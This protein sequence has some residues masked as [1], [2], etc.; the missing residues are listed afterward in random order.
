M[1]TTAIYPSVDQPWLKY[2]D[3]TK[4][5]LPLPD[6]TL[7]EYT[8]Q[9]NQGNL[10]S[11]AL[12]YFGTKVSYGQFFDRIRET[13]KAFAA[14]GIQKGDIVTIMSIST[15][16]T[17][18][19]IFALNYMG[20]VGNMVYM[21][22]SEHE[23]LQNLEFTESKLFMVLDPALDRVNKIKD[24]LTVPTVVL[25]VS[26]SMPLPV[27]TIFKLK[28]K[29]EKHDFLTWKDFY[30]KGKGTELPEQATDSKALAYIVY[31]SGTTGEPKGVMLSSDNLTGLVFAYQAGG[32]RFRP[33]DTFLNIIP[34]FLGY[35][36]GMLSM[37]LSS[38][39]DTNLW[40]QLDPKDVAG[41]I[42]KFKPDHVE[43]G[44]AFID[45]V[46]EEDLDLSNCFNFGAGGGSMAPDKEQEVHEYLKEHGCKENFVLGYGMTEF[47]SGVCTNLHQKCKISS[48]G[49]PLPYANMKIID[50]ETK[51]ELPIGKTGEIC[52]AAPN[53]MMGYYK[54]P[55]ATAEVIEIDENGTR[56]L[57]TG[58]L[59]KVD[60]DGFVFF[61]G[62]IKRV[63]YI[64]MK[65]GTVFRLFPQR[66]EELLEAQPEVDRCGAILKNDEKRI[67]CSIAY[68][69]LKDPNADKDAAAAA[70]RKVVAENLPDH[71]RPDDVI[72]IDE[73]PVTTV[74][75][76]DYKKLGEEDVQ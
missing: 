71:Q 14:M 30:K 74:G 43:I 33:G 34:C 3:E 46:L 24:K 21:T 51:E 57:H 12:Y 49:V 62:R 67:S 9:N 15:P 63:A 68:V 25:P 41:A 75:K 58:D 28:E 18:Y 38:G 60:K 35:G 73:L 22:L 45:A 61:K 37:A 17:V 1:A 10:K 36:I 6:K 69:T 72:V 26:E 5:N 8:W 19:A 66:I 23:I 40:I 54:N 2:Y 47:A 4:L 52:F 44:V 39:L 50:P 76:V 55:E 29:T 42:K 64:R 65:D 59:A 56:W 32:F 27:K 13:A 7:Y 70:L 31:T 48:M 20:A 16:E 11:N 53:M